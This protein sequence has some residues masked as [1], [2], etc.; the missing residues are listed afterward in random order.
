MNKL[1]LASL[2]V[3]LHATIQEVVKRIDLSGRLSLALLV[4]EGNQ[5]RA[6]ITDGDVRRGLLEGFSLQDPASRLLEVKARMPN[7]VAVTSTLGEDPTVLLQLMQERHVRQIPL[8]DQ[9]GRVADIVTMNDLLPTQAPEIRAVIMAGGIGARLRPL[10]D[11]M[12]KPMLSVAGRPAME[13]I[14]AQ[15][16]EAGIRRMNVTTHYKPEKIKNYFGDGRAFGVE[17][18]Y[19][20]EELPLGTGGA[21]GLMDPPDG[22]FLVINGDVI[23]HLDILKM[24]DF[25]SEHRADITVGIHQ[26]KL[27]VPFGVV[28]CTG[29]LLT[30]LREKPTLSL[31]VN[32]GIYMLEPSVYTFIPPGGEHFNMTDLIQWLLD[33]G[34]KVVG[35][36]IMEYWSDIGEHQSYRD[37]QS[38]LA[39]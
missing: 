28:D 19:V 29:P 13:W 10:T 14:V 33:A 32:A 2:H 26:Q 35:F 6:V 31:M 37:V 39:P 4:E 36:P 21:L 9:A 23:T 30:Q 34:R 11:D 15:L 20:N 18:N 12:P 25:H 3:P 38:H 17:L 8:L 1:D 22:P 24:L 27:E 16:R 5:L 7:P